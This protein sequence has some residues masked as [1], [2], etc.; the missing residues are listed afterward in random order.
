[1]SS[2]FESPD[3][4][5]PERCRQT[6]QSR[7]TKAGVDPSFVALALY[8]LLAIWVCCQVSSGPPLP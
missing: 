5:Q 1:M 7:Q 8:A 4:A 3:A 6:E 2:A